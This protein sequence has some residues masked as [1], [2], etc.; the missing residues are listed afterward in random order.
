MSKWYYTLE[1]DDNFEEIDG[2][3]LHKLGIKSYIS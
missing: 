2:N 3:T 1:D